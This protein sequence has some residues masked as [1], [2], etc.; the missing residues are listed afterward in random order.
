MSTAAVERGDPARLFD[1]ERRLGK[2]SYSALATSFL[3]PRSCVAES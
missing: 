1:K 3:S 2:V